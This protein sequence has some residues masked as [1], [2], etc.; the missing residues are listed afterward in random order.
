MTE[1]L[2]PER[3]TRETPSQSS[4]VE[5]A[6]PRHAAG[7]HAFGWWGMVMLIA[8]ESMLFLALVASYFFLRFQSGPEW[9]PDGIAAPSLEL[10]L[11]MTVI[12]LSSSIP[13]HIADRAIRRGNSRRLRVGLA[14]GFVLGAAFLGLQGV[15]YA[16]KLS[17]FTPT[18]NAY[19]SLFYTIT[20]FHGLHVLVGLLFSIW[21]QAR[22]WRAAF[23]NERHLTVQNFTLYWHFVDAVWIVV[24][25]TIYLSPNL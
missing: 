2:R 21:T 24:L 15:E 25:A 11:V 17:E 5:A 4:L 3:V 20:G 22:A 18:T 7:S 10:P 1:T 16:E 19:G 13:V 6:L 9:P 23:D 14:V 8:T 12:L